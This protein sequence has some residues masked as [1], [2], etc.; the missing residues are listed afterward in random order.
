MRRRL[1]PFALVLALIGFAAIS[2]TN[3]VWASSSKGG[4]SVARSLEET[5]RYA[6][7][8]SATG[9]L[10]RTDRSLLRISSPK[11]I[12]VLVKLDYDALG[13]YAGGIRGLRPTSP[14]VTGRSL[15]SNGPAVAAYRSYVG[16]LEGRVRRDIAARIPTAR[17]TASFRLA[18]GGLAVQLPGNQASRLLA[19][20]GVVAVQRDV[21]RRP[22]VVK[23]PYQFIGARAVWPALGGSKFAGDNVIVANI[24]TGIWPENPMLRDKGLPAPTGGPFAC[25]FGLSGDT[26]DPVFACNHKVI[27]AQAFTDTYTTFLGAEPGEFCTDPDPGNPDPHPWTCSARDSDGHG[28]H[29]ITTA[30]GDLVRHASMLGI[31][32]GKTSGMAPGAHVIGYR[33]CLDQ[34]CFESDSVAAVNQAID[35]GVNVLNFSISG[36]N[37]PYSDPVELA[38]LD[39]YGAGILVNASAG[40]AGPGSATADHGGPWVNTV[41]ASYASRIFQG[42]LTLSAGNGDTLHARGSTITPG[43]SSPTPVVRPEDVAGYTGHNTCDEPF[44]PGSVDG[45]IVLC[46]RGN[47]AGRADSGFEV[48]QGDGAGMILANVTHQDLF[49]DLHWVPAIMV[50]AGTWQGHT[51]P[52]DAVRSFVATHSDVT[53][54]FTTGSRHGLR[55]DIMTTF[56]SRGPL[57]DWVKPDVTAPGIEILAGR[58]PHPWSGAIPSGPPGDNFMAIAGTS[59]SAPHATGVAALVASAHPSWTPGQVKSA[60]MTSAVQD[61]LKPDGVTPAD[62][63]NDGAGAI[64]ANRA[65]RPTLTFD[66]SAG[67]YTAL[68]ADPLHRIDANLPSVDASEFGGIVTTTRTGLNVSGRS[69]SFTVTTEAPPGARIK[70]TP[71]RFTLGPNQA[72]ELSIKIIG[73]RLR[74]HVQYFGSISIDAYRSSASDVFM[75]VAFFKQQGA[76]SLSNQC[77]PG[78]IAPRT[79]TDCEAVAQNLSSNDATAHLRGFSRQPRI[80]DIRRER[81]SLDRA[82]GHITRPAN[83]YVWDG[84]LDP[85]VAPEIVSIDP[86][87]TPV[88]GYLPLRTLG[89]S[90]IPGM[91]DETLANFGTDP[92][93]WGHETY[94]TIGVDS[95]GY[96]VVG[97]GTSADNDFVPQTFPD[98]ARP[99][100]VIAP[101]WTDL[102]PSQDGHT[103]NAG[104]RIAELTD[105]ADVWIV[106]DWEEVATFGTCQ[107]G[108]CDNNTF[109]IWIGINGDAHPAEDVTFALAD[110]GTGAGNPLNTGAENRDGSS[111][112]NVVPTPA[113]DTQWAITTGA[114]VPGG[115]VTITYRAFGLRRGTAILPARLRSDQ[116][117]G[118]TSEPTTVRVG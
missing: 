67:D 74:S 21:L 112:V 107:P 30:A 3:A 82:T 51:Q 64:R 78:A 99:N 46:D 103:A 40:N 90:P 4:F 52:G 63:F 105:G 88:D 101:W 106:V 61:V 23:E 87:Q 110:V 37:T 80:V 56:S 70:V 72:Q 76:V 28:T 85:S 115:R 111:G 6:G 93:S 9:R 54:T 33:V 94:D 8:K 55:P 31:D 42:S 96:V 118:T 10:A 86:G 91:G 102:N 14:T 1:V 34:G 36:G 66:E 49:T 97:G 75:P 116:I 2:A 41:G 26:N 29:T 95:N 65:V 22:L 50:D 83:G 69:Q 32:R 60:L 7:A 35:D 45:K 114:P 15:R 16:R 43:I 117:V 13:S 89:V 59:M 79:S 113:D 5:G 71:A 100:N 19:I 47:P 39:A 62:P 73:E 48:L 11:V 84:T 18:Y 92:Y 68:A 53:A 104:I 77:S 57:G 12:P 108:P 44:A 98:P 38:F 24:D 17:V 58:S 81:A 20:P 27:G 109:E 25:Q